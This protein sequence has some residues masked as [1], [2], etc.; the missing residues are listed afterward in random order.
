[1]KVQEVVLGESGWLSVNDWQWEDLT[2]LVYV[3]HGDNVY[4]WT[5]PET[6]KTYLSDINDETDEIVAEQAILSFLAGYETETFPQDLI[7]LIASNDDCDKLSEN[8][9]LVAT[10]QSRQ[11]D[12]CLMMLS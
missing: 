8:G 1:M 11:R 5:D 9:I 4:I 3:E 7:E 12:K 10:A 6:E 2:D